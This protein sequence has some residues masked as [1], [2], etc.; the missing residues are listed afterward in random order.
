MP[1]YVLT[2]DE[3]SKYSQVVIFMLFSVVLP[4]IEYVG[5]LIQLLWSTLQEEDM[6]EPLALSTHPLDPSN[7]ILHKVAT[8]YYIIVNEFFLFCGKVWMNH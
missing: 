6:D 2:I 4:T 5:N 7:R 3:C 1:L 8:I